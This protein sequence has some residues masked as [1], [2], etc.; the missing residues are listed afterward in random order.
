MNPDIADAIGLLREKRVLTSEQAAPL[1]RLARRELVSVELE[2]RILLYAGVLLVTAGVGLFLKE[3]HERLG[4]ATIVAVLGAAAAACLVFAWRRLPPFSWQA[5]ESPHLAADYVLLLGLLLL[6]ADLAYAEARFRFLGPNWPYHLLLVA[7]I[8]LAAAYRFDSRAALSLALTSL[9]AWRGVAVSLSFAT[10]SAA[11]I[12]AVRANALVC[13]AV[14]AAAGILSARKRRK[15]HFE[16]V[17]VTLGLLLV[18]GGLLSGA[19]QGGGSDWAAWEIA[20]W[21]VA[22]VVAAVAYRLRRALD[23]ALAVLAAYLGLLRVLADALNGTTMMLVVAV[24]SLAVVALLVAAQRRM[25][26]TG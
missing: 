5:T 8:A 4:P 11:Q 24:T 14:F 18:F 3:N 15:A 23:F 1:L 2:L 25:K 26:E 10:S 6:A 13:G 9:A 16:P 12:P 21:L 19:F 20:L 17:F 22:A 7:L